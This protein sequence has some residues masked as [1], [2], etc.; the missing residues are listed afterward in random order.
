ML[1]RLLEAALNRRGLVALIFLLVTGAGALALADLKVD[2]FPDTT[3]IQ[4]QI[5]TVAPTLNPEEVELQISYPIESAI[6]GIPGLIDVRSISKFG[7]S[8]V[9]ATFVDGTSVL[10]ARQLV[11]NG[12][13]RW[14]LDR[15]YPVRLWGRSPPVSARSSTTY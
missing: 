5:N 12:C 14:N 4:V 1:D 2:A 15:E 11:R 9:V 10:D 7:F 3:P 6:S 8:Q 13:M